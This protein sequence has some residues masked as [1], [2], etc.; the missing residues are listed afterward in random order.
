MS[1]AIAFSTTE[2]TES[3]RR[4]TLTG[5]FPSS[6][7]RT[8]SPKGSPTSARAQGVESVNEARAT[9]AR[10]LGT[11]EFLALGGPDANT[12]DALRDDAARIATNLCAIT[13]AFVAMEQGEEEAVEEPT[14]RFAR[15][16][17]SGITAHA[18]LDPK[19]RARLEHLC[20]APVRSLGSLLCETSFALNK[21]AAAF[22]R[23][24]G[25]IDIEMARASVGYDPRDDIRTF[26]RLLTEATSA[27]QTGDYEL[28]YIRSHQQLLAMIVSSLGEKNEVVARAVGECGAVGPLGSFLEEDAAP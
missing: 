5:V 1:T 4:R 24:A 20:S 12:L 10:I 3:R 9:L 23:V 18:P 25:C 21:M 28:A 14:L 2:P 19:R 8:P 11:L 15:Q 16:N 27:V 17:G 26:P 13:S 6:S 7:I 22:M